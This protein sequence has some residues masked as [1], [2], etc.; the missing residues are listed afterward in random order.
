MPE[1]QL[2][3]IRILP[4][5]AIARMGSAEEAMHNYDIAP[6]AN[7]Q[8]YAQLVP[9]ETLVVDPQNGHIIRTVTPLAVSFRDGLGRI[10]PVSPFLEL[11]GRFSGDGTFEPLTLASLASLGL[12][13]RDVRWT[14]EVAN[15]KMFRR[16]GHP[17]D[18]ITTRLDPQEIE[19]HQRTELMGR[20]NHFRLNTSVS[21]GFLQYVRPTP[22]FPDIRI[23]FT[24]AHGLVFGHT[25]N[26]VI[27]PAR[28]IYNAAIGD[29]D[30]HTDSNIPVNSSTPRARSSTVPGRIYA[31]TP[32]PQVNRGYFDDACDGLVRALIAVGDKTLSAVARICSG[33]PDFAP[34]LAPVRS[35]Q[36]DLDQ[37]ANGPEVVTVETEVISIVRRA[38][39][40]IRLMSTENE[41]ESFPFWVSGAQ[42]S[43]G[44]GGARYFPT[45]GLHEGILDAVMGLESADAQKR[46]AAVAALR[47]L[48]GVLR[49]VSETGNYSFQSSAGSRP[50]IQQMPALMR[51]SD[52][53][54]LTLTQRQINILTRAISQFDIGGDTDATPLGAMRR[55]ISSHEF[56]ATLHSGVGLPQGGALGDLFADPDA[57]IAYM[58]NPATGARSG[59]ASSLGIAGQRMVV[60]QNSGASALVT[61]VS[62]GG[63][64]MNAALSAYSDVLL[65]I[66]GIQVIELWINSLPTQ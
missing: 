42:N 27:P 2:E 61:L 22:E 59:F 1:R 10:K 16:T 48:A 55:L 31:Q 40:T 54:L 60:P 66:D 46:A 53:G 26:D 19:T 35:V 8:S 21:F 52:G 29:W 63:H 64:P 41:N 9:A 18:R 20:S 23:R 39:E 3:E 56:A 28:A 7:A 43:F 15:L 30:M 50:P 45:R 37:M 11:W 4:P 12:Q 47:R 51:G 65:N 5:L 38:V 36:D 6:P 58:S 33:P 32:S 49:P 14:V 13:P 17:N 62:Q 25:A 24:P 34:Q 44:A 57:L